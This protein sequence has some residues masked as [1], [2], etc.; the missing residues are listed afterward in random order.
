MHSSIAVGPL[1]RYT[2]ARQVVHAKLCLSVAA[3]PNTRDLGI[4][5]V[6]I[7]ANLFKKR[8]K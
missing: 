4:V 6:D 7:Y 1:K 5:V 2:D 8:F 3:S